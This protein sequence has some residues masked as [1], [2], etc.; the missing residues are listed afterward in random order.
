MSSTHHTQSQNHHPTRTAPHE[1]LPSKCTYFKAGLW[2]RMMQ[3]KIKKL[4]KGKNDLLKSLKLE[5]GV[6]IPHY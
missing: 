5:E 3:F 6:P 4:G 2:G 1:M